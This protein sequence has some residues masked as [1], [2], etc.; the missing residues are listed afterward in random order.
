[1]ENITHSIIPGRFGIDTTVGKLHIEF[2][3]N[4]KSMECKDYRKKNVKAVKF[5]LCKYCT[6]QICLI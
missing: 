5:W 3:L 2:F 4:N 1:M 6:D